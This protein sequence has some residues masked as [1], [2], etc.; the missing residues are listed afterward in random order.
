MNWED[1]IKSYSDNAET[2]SI[3]MKKHLMKCMS[4]VEVFVNNNPEVRQ[5]IKV[6]LDDITSGIIELS[7]SIVNFDASLKRQ[8]KLR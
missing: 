2:F 6:E 4:T 3:E 7:E 5:D 1:I 8:E